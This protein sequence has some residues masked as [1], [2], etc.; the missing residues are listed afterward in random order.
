MRDA[1]GK[2]WLLVFGTIMI[3]MGALEFLVLFIPLSSPNAPTNDTSLFWFF[4]LAQSGFGIYLGYRGVSAANKPGNERATSL[5]VLCVVSLVIPLAAMALYMTRIM[6]LLKA[7]SLPD[8]ASYLGLLFFLNIL[9]PLLLLPGGIIH[10]KTAR[11][12]A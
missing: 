11:P 10:K 4:A 9:M 7:I 12:V 5:I 6:E 3:V 8:I 1:P 2:S